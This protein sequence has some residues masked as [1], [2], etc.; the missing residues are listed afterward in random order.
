MSATPSA[1]HLDDVSERV[2][3]M[4]VELGVDDIV[5]PFYAYSST[6][7]LFGRTYRS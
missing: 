2:P 3:D 4:K 5:A 1:D 7:P 6:G